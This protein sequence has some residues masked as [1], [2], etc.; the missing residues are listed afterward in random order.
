[1]F[2]PTLSVPL[3][4]ANPCNLADASLLI[5]VSTPAFVVSDGVK[6]GVS[7]YVY[8]PLPLALADG[9]ASAVASPLVSV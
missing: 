3:L 1:V 7:F 2:V 4:T 8:L 5:M 9:L 6:F